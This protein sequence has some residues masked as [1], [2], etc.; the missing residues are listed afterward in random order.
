MTEM[1]QKF[2]DNYNRLTKQTERELLQRRI[3]EA[4]EAGQTE[5]KSEDYLNGLATALRI[6]KTAQ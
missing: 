5:G 2:W 1:S 6:V 3:N 4:L